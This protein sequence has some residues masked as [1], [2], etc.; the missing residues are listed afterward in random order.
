MEK[1]PNRHFSKEDT[2]MANR[3]ME[4]F[5]MS[6]I[7]RE[8]QIK[9]QWD[10]TSP[11]SEWLSSI[12]QQ[13]TSVGEDAEKREPPGTVG[14]NAD[15]CSHCGK[16]YGVT[17]KNKKWNWLMTQNS[18]SGNLSNETWTT[19]S[20]EYMHPY[21]H[22]SIIYNSHNLETAQMPISRWMDKKVVVHL[23]MEYYVAVKK[24]EVLPFVT[25][26]MDLKY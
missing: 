3:H 26:W 1:G 7:I 25:A 8:M 20:K 21:V 5:S 19:N 10:I 12:C 6:L 11:L 23:H 14:G 15:W 2:Q 24:M 16:Q 4:R 9:L 13:T 17:S 22:C 18:T